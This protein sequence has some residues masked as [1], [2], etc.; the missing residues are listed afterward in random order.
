MLKANFEQLMS[1]R[2]CNDSGLLLWVPWGHG[3]EQDDGESDFYYCIFLAFLCMFHC[4]LT[5][6]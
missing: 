5:V 3:L 2:N 4:L 1:D 6:Y